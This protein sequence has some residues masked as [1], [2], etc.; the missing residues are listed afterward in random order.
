ML[1]A[2]QLAQLKALTKTKREAAASGGDPGV[3]DS[4][5]GTLEQAPKVAGAAPSASQ[6]AAPAPTTDPALG[7]FLEMA[8]MTHLAAELGAATL[9]ELQLCRLKNRAGCGHDDLVRLLARVGGAGIQR[10]DERQRFA[11]SLAGWSRSGRL[12]PPPLTA[13]PPRP[14]ASSSG[15]GP[16]PPPPHAEGRLAFLFLVYETIL[17][18]QLWLDF[19]AQAPPG[20]FTVYVHAKTVVPMH[21]FFAARRLS[22]AETVPTNWGDITLVHAHNAL[23]RT[24]LAD[25]AN[26]KFVS[27]SQACIPLKP[28]A[29]VDAEL[30]RDDASR[31]DAT[32]DGL[33]PH[34]EPLL[35]PADDGSTMLAREDAA[36]AAN[37]WVLNR[38]AARLSV[39][40][41]AA[42]VAHFARIRSPEEFYYLST[43]RAAARR[44][45]PGCQ[46]LRAPVTYTDWR[47]SKAWHPGHPKTFEHIQLEELFPLVHS[48]H[49]FARKFAARCD[50]LEPLRRMHREAAAVYR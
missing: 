6:A 25:E 21:P 5:A 45:E 4:K 22:E 42:Y 18:E 16:P 26:R 46:T 14:S 20:R 34:A 44:G 7:S 36:K 12:P 29:Y 31:F 30:A 39:S 3:A 11:H 24:A 27:L 17:H 19:F 32:L 23:L 47:G 50:G 2:E 43:L 48:P 35:E 1:S 33:W 38:A 40:Q 15:D 10:L 28:F 37:W 41:P 13:P 8:G 49:L 9:E